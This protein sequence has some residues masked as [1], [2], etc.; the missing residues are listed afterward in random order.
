MRVRALCSGAFIT[1]SSFIFQSQS[2]G[3]PEGWNGFHL[4]FSPSISVNWKHSTRLAFIN[5]VSNRLL[6]SSNHTSPYSP[7]WGFLGAKWDSSSFV[8]GHKITETNCSWH[9]FFKLLFFLQKYTILSHFT[10]N[11]LLKL[12]IVQ[13][14]SLALQ[15]FRGGQSRLLLLR[16]QGIQPRQQVCLQLSH[17]HL[18]DPFG[19]PFLALCNKNK[20]KTKQRLLRG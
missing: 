7:L 15:K 6:H 13:P 18:L 14:F 9:K 20:N 16:V 5:A 2:K 10:T 11:N 17:K 8:V 19:P 12:T 3:G 4:V 1:R